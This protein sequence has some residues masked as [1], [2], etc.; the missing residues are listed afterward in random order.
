LAISKIFHIVPCFCEIWKKNKKTEKT[1]EAKNLESGE[2]IGK[3]WV[4]SKWLKC[5]VSIFFFKKSIKGGNTFFLP[6]KG[7]KK[8]PRAL[9]FSKVKIWV[10]GGTGRAGRDPL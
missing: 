7:K 9:A 4:F 3:H 1:D 6:Q 5:L 2:T 10:P 8:L